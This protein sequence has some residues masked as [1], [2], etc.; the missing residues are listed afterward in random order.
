MNN[1]MRRLDAAQYSTRLIIKIAPA[2]ILRK[3]SAIIIFLMPAPFNSIETVEKVS[4]NFSGYTSIKGP[5]STA[6][7][8]IKKIIPERGPLYTVRG[9]PPPI[10]TRPWRK[11]NFFF[12]Q[13]F[14]KEKTCNGYM[15]SMI[16]IMIISIPRIKI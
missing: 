6:M 15:S 5:V 4:L 3:A 14:Q 13:Y 11:K 12:V 16:P 1:F 2:Q 8:P 10:R 7:R 9:N